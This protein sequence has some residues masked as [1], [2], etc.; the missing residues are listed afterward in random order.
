MGNPKKS[1]TMDQHTIQKIKIYNAYLI[2][3]LNIILRANFPKIHIF[4][5]F[6]GIG[7]YENENG[8]ALV[9]CE[10]IKR[11]AP[12]FPNTSISL[13]LN[14]KEEKYIS[15]LQDICNFDFVKCID[16][17]PAKQFIQKQCSHEHDGPKLWFIDPC[18]YTQVSEQEITEIMRQAKSEILLFIPLTFIYRF[19]KGDHRNPRLQSIANF[20]NSYSIDDKKAQQCES[21]EDFAKLISS[22][23]QDKYEY[24][25]HAS[26]K[27]SSNTYSL[28]FIS[29]HHYGLDKFLEARD[30]ILDKD[31]TIQLTFFPVGDESIVLDLL[32]TNNGL[33]NCQLYKLGINNG[34][35]PAAMNKILKILERKKEITITPVGVKN[36][37][38]G[39][40]YNGSDYYRKNDI[41]TII[42]VRQ[43]QATLLNF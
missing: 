36:R 22:T 37:K 6:S 39:S 19:L 41:R 5:P 28:F 1:I 11:V 20:L 43:E 17:S 14:D 32:R 40:F 21:V 7:K 2:R 27:E 9:A 33:N 12:Q 35:R 16:C 30:F 29:Q 13:Y 31:K 15:K 38:K 23:M 8:S 42:N 26:L 34:Y 24:A 3:Y 10:A 25:W 18:G 4:D